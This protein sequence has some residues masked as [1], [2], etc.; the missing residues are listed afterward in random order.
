MRITVCVGSSCHLRGSHKV[1]EQLKSLVSQNGLKD[2]VELAGAFCLG[3]CTSGVSVKI[4]DK[5]FSIQ[6]ETTAAFF[7]QEV[8]KLL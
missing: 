3:R 7:E 4:D 8:L 5:D 6:P 1:A 2:K